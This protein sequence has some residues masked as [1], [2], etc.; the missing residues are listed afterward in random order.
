M[1]SLILALI[2]LFTGIYAGIAQKQ[3]E[4]F[5]RT[6][7]IKYGSKPAVDHKAEYSAQYDLIIASSSFY[8]MWAEGGLN[9]WQTLKKYNPDIII[10]LYQMGP[11]EFDV[12]AGLLGNSWDWIKANHGTASGAD[13]WTATGHKYPY[14]ANSNYP[15]E[16]LMY[17]KNPEWQKY[18][19]EKTYDDRYVKRLPD[20]RESDAIFSDNTNFIV[21]WPNAWYDENNI[22]KEEFKDHPKDYATADG[23]YDNA[24]WKDDMKSLL[25]SSV[26]ILSKKPVRVKMILNFGYMGRHPEYWIELDSMK[27]TVYAAMEEGAFTNPWNKTYTI[28]DWETKIKIM[29]DLKNIIALMNNTGRIT[30][31]EGMGKMD[32]LMSDGNMGPATGW[33][34]LWF[35]M[36]SFLM[37][38]NEDKTNGIFGFTIWGY[39]E[40]YY[41]DEYN[42]ENLH[43]GKAVAD[44]YIPVSGPSKD[45]AFREYEDGWV[46]TSKPHTGAKKAVP[47]PKGQAY[48]VTHSNLKDPLSGGLVKTFDIGDNRGLILLKKGKKI[49]NQDNK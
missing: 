48:V 27:N 6:Y 4:K 26:K 40:N 9:S 17:I 36:T 44:Y 46:V 1:K 29:K 24:T 23:V 42:P 47:V 15:E 32:V 12:D 3:D 38:L 28:S 16:R 2:I 35:S 31:G 11:S 49:G 21:A 7:Y 18:W 33:D 20:F 37:A 10:S 5:F 41:L 39:G 25:S 14:L 13:R 43:L 34:A 22:G 8:N 45:V 30:T 19:T